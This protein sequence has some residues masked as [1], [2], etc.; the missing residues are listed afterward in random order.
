M[1]HD[2]HDAKRKESMK[3]DQIVIYKDENNAI[4]LEVRM[5]G[6]MIN[7][8]NHPAAD[9]TLCDVSPAGIGRL[10]L[11]APRG[12]TDDRQVIR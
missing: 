3:Q 12:A 6:E 2:C 1:W 11:P 5:D 8:G 9:C 7:L 4:Q 10:A